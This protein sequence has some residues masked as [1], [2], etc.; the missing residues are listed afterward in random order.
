MTK[1]ATKKKAGTNKEAVA[2]KPILS[3]PAGGLS[4]KTWKDVCKFHNRDPKVFPDVS[5][6]PKNLQ[7]FITNTFKA[8]LITSAVNDNWTPN[9]NNYS[10]YKYRL[11]FEIKASK[12]KPSGF[13]CSFTDCGYA[14]SGT[15]VGSR[16]LFKSSELALHA[17]KCFP[18]IYKGI[19]LIQ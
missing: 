4:V 5:S 18:E 6:F 2:K 12:Q 19:I 14:G 16:L 11:W 13:G 10:E 9:W 8:A 15:T 1:Q 3:K 7:D 17:A